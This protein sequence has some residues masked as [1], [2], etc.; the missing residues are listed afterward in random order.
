MEDEQGHL[1]QI[2]HSQQHLLILREMLSEDLAQQPL[3]LRLWGRG[4]ERK[5]LEHT[6][7]GDPEFQDL[8]H[9]ACS[10]GMGIPHLRADLQLPQSLRVVRGGDALLR[11]G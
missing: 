11:D 5:N 6:R 10:S 8:P 3:P 7:E 4:Q 9:I 1:L 2:L